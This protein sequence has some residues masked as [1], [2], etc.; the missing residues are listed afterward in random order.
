MTG[1]QIETTADSCKGFVTCAS[2]GCNN[3]VLR[4]RDLCPACRIAR[5]VLNLLASRPEPSGLGKTGEIQ[6]H[7]E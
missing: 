2:P 4:G 1:E 7:E 5:G 3:R 6:N